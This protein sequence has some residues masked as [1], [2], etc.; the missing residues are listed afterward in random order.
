[1]KILHEPVYKVCED[2]TQDRLYNIAKE[3]NAYIARGEECVI[4][5]GHSGEDSD[6]LSVAVGKADNFVVDGAVLY[7]DFEIDDHWQKDIKRHTK[8]SCEVWSDDVISLVSLLAKNRPALELGTVKYE[9]KPREGLDRTTTK[10]EEPEKDIEDMNINEIKQLFQECLDH[11]DIVARFNELADRIIPTLQEKLVKLEDTLSPLLEEEAAEPEHA[12]IAPQ[13]EAEG[14]E[15]KAEEGEQVEAGKEEAVPEVKEESP[16]AE[17]EPGKKEMATASANNTYTPGFEGGEKRDDKEEEEKRKKV[18]EKYQMEALQAHQEK[19]EALRKYQMA[20]RRSEL[21][22]L[23]VDRSFDLEEELKLVADLNDEQFENHKRIVVTRYMRA[24]V[25]RTVSPATEIGNSKDVV[26]RAEKANRAKNL[27]LS[28]GIT[29]KE[30]L[31][32]VK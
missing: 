17:E 9:M 16:L 14:E 15:I 1:M 5:L 23:N 18:L 28:E 13:L 4:C 31:E 24:P 3:T 25:G 6:Q 20:V 29:F 32:K 8:K 30:A 12:D 27:A 22:D 26:V 10:Y 7:C 11:S 2:A 19:N 21:K